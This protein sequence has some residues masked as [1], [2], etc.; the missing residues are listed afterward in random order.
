MRGILVGGLLLLIP[1][2]A[3]AAEPSPEGP[4]LA[5]EVVFEATLRPSERVAHAS[6]R[7]GAG[8]DAM[9]WLR[10]HIDPE[11][12]KGFEGDG[13][14]E[15]LGDRVL[16]TP[17]ASGG[18]LRYVF[19]IDHLRTPSS[20]DARCAEHWAL[21]RGDDLFPRAR[22][23]TRKGATSVSTLRLRVPDGWS[24]A[25]PYRRIADA[26]FEVRNESRQFDRPTGWMLAGRLGI[27]RERIAGSRVAVA[28]PI[29]Q[30]VRRQDMLA[31]L[32]WTL[33][34]LR[35]ALGPLPERLLVVSAGDPMWRG[36]LSGPA[37]V[38]VH[39]LRPLIENDTTSP[40]LHELVHTL[41]RARAG[42]GGDWIVEGLAE[43]YS[44][45]V[46]ARSRTIS[47]RRFRRALDR[48]EKKGGAAVDL[49]ADRADTVV[50]ARAV[51]LLHRL[52]EELRTE[53]GRELSLDDVVRVLAREGGP[54]TTE[55]LRAAIEEVAGRD[56]L[57]RGVLR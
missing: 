6:I 17:P 42:E 4:D 45:E 16:W 7:L 14:V 5:Y 11:R 31:F 23:R 29:G 52:D 48:L 44:L 50:A 49:Q 43:L 47:R 9:R 26:T 53:P 10:F 22:V 54:I 13:R 18:V 27:S 20:Y 39:A 57:P 37:S 1:V 25:V 41:M 36:G 51:G 55:A 34:T 15:L 12:H 35:D 40:L 46:L 21:F 8:A 3:A 28:G 32:R 56:L 30:G 24:M 2:A 33:P 19:H 38:Y